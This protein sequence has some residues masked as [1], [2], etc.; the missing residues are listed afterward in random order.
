MPAKEVRSIVL[1][2]IHCITDFDVHDGRTLDVLEAIVAEGVDAVQ[3]RAKSLT[4][5]ELFALTETLLDRLAAT[6]AVVVVNDR[7]DVAL[8]AGAHGVHL[9]PDDLPV[10][11]ARRLAPVGFLVGATC[12]DAAQ[13]RRALESGADYAGV[14]PVYPTTTKVGLPAPIGLERLAEAARVL[15]V[16]A[17]AGITAERVPEVVAAGAHGVAVAGAICRAPDP[18]AAARSIAEALSAS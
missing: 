13:A 9:G 16:V 2:R 18:P 10:S 4:D 1:P 8:A 12:R 6:T 5:R 14:G 3:V 17:I 7:I 11:V 15:P